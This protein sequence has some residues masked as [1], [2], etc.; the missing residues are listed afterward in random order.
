VV[1][2]SDVNKHHILVLGVGN[3]MK[4]DDGIGPYV[5]ERVSALY[6]CCT[7]PG[8][9]VV[10]AID[11]GTV[12]EN[13][14]SAI[15]RLQP[16]L[17]VIVDAAQMGL[18]TGEYR[19]IAADRVGNLGLSTHSMPLSLFMTYVKG[20]AGAIVLIGVQPCSM[21]FGA[22]LSAAVRQAGDALAQ[23]LANDRIGDIKTL[24]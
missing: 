8:V 4:G 10:S 2:S 20:F 16:Q 12:P 3:P 14:T 18:Q 11:C 13:F 21:D 9:A 19:I 7:A 1:D 15:R 5:A 17:I 6:A 24:D 23:L 22:G